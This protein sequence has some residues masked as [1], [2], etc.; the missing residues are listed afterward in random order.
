MKYFLIFILFFS[1]SLFANDKIQDAYNELKNNKAIFLDVRE[2]PEVRD[3][4]IKDAIWLPLSQIE[5]NKEWLK[6]FKQQKAN[7]KVYL[8]CRSGKR[9]TKV[10]TILHENGIDSINI[11]GYENLKKFLPTTRK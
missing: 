5:K 10:K 2:E 8:Y 9:A 4:M 1:S 7:K 6:K 11:G 3:G